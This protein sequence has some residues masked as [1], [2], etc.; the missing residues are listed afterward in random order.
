MPRASPL[1]SITSGNRTLVANSRLG[2]SLKN[3]EPLARSFRVVDT[4]RSENDETW[5]PVY[6]ER[7]EIRDHYNQFEVDLA[8]SQ[9]PPRRVTLRFRAY[10]EGIAFCYHF[11]KQDGLNNFVIASE[12]TQFAFPDDF[13]CWPV[14]SAQGVY[15][16]AKLSE[17]K[18][19]CERPLVVQAGGRCLRC[20]R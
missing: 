3:G 1:T 17:V 9:T 5:Q 11:P 19:N 15:S 10:N 20:R 16:H 12:L 6:G 2:L 13:G 14:Y 7:S 18:P 8:D 4:R